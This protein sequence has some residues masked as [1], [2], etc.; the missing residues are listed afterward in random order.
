MNYLF[1]ELD[2][3]EGALKILFLQM[4]NLLSPAT[5]KPKWLVWESVR[6]LPSQCLLT[7]PGTPPSTGPLPGPCPQLFWVGLA[8]CVSYVR[9]GCKKKRDAQFLRFDFSFLI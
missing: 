8:S 3:L 5:S 1:I 4:F 9:T 6:C 7:C 2:C